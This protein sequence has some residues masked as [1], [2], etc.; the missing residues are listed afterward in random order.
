MYLHIIQFYLHGGSIMK[1]DIYSVAELVDSI[2]EEYQLPTDGDDAW[3]TY[4]QR[5]SRTL[6]STGIWDKGTKK[7]VG[8]KTTMYFTYQQRQVLL[9]EKSFYNYLRD[10][11]KSVEIKNSRR[12]DEIQKAIDERRI[13]Y[14]EYLDS[15]DMS[16]RDEN[17]PVITNREFKEYKRDMMITALFE[18]FFT[19]IDDELLLTDLY[20]VQIFKNELCLQVEDIEA[21]DRLSN[22]NPYYYKERK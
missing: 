6:K 2:I 19:P 5:V 22:P 14:I 16:E 3:G 15:L 4:R 10:R 7:T 20:Q 13:E 21:E 18:K 12:Y 8:K 1:K 9:S 11:S 17:N